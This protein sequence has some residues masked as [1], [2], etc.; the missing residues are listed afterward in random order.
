MCIFMLVTAMMGLCVANAADPIGFAGLDPYS[1]RFKDV[2]E[3]YLRGAQYA[4]SV[5]NR[6][7]GLLGREVKIIALDSEIKPEVAA[8]KMEKA[9]LEDKIK[10][11]GAG[12]SSKVME[13]M[14]DLAKKHNVLSI[15][16][17]AEAASATGKQC[18]R[19]FFR[20]CLNTDTH[21]NALAAWVGKSGKTKVFCVAQDYSFGKEAVEAFK[22]KLKQVKPSAEIVGE[23]YHKMGETDFTAHISQIITSKAEIVFT[24][25]WGNDLQLLLKQAKQLDLKARFACYYLNDSVGIQEIGNN[26]SVIGHIASEW[27]MLAIPLPENKA[28]IEGYR[29]EYGVPPTWSSGKAYMAVMF[30]AEA[31]KKAGTADDVDKIIKAWEGLSYNSPAGK[32]IMR[33]YDHQNQTPVWIAEIV[34]DNKSPN[35]YI[36]EPA[37]I[38]AEE[39]SVPVQETGCAGLGR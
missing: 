17:G 15:S 20:C 33:A 8:Q 29:K 6:Q 31:V 25:N 13:V 16:W 22:K 36:G 18:S 24:P 10:F 21:S 19:N 12:A 11:F 32:Q 27:Y 7:G 4:A 34:K 26:D 30:W 5:I 2:G 38:S 14:S 39:I 28:F 1:G 23:I 3:R 35:P 9:I 37:M